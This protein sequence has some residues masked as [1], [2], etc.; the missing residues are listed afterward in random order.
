[1]DDIIYDLL[2][3]Y[4]SQMKYFPSTLVNIFILH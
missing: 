3:F 1:M 4:A 2:C